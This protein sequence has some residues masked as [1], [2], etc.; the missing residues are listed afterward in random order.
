[1]TRTLSS[2]TIRF[3]CLLIC[4]GLFQQSATAQVTTYPYFE[5]FESGAG[6]WTAGKINPNSSPSSWVLTLPTNYSIDTAYSGVNAWVTGNSNNIA[7]FPQWSYFPGEFSAVTSPEFDFTNLQNPGI[8]VAIWW[9]SEFSQDGTCFQSSID[10]GMTWQTVGAYIDP[11]NWYN[12]SSVNGGML[13]GPGGQPLGWSGLDSVNT[14]PG[15]YVIAQ[16]G[17]DGLGGQPSVLL[18]FAFSSNSVSDSVSLSD[19]FAFDDVFIADRPIIDVGPDTLICFAERLILD[20]C[21]PGATT[22]QWNNNPIDTFCNIIAVTTGQ[23]FVNVTDTLGFI[24]SD[25]MNL[26]VSDTYA[27]L[28]SDIGLCPGDTFELDAENPWADHLW[29]P[30]SSTN[31]VIQ[32]FESGSFTVEISDSLGC[33]AVDSINVIVDF[34]PDTDL[35]A[36]TSICAGENI[37]LDASSGNPGTTY[38]WSPISASSQTVSIAA[39]GTYAVIVTS[40]FGCLTG[41]TVNI[42]VNP[43]PSVNLGVDRMVCPPFEINAGNT[44]ATYAWTTN[45]TTQTISVTQNGLYG[46]TVTTDSGCARYDEVNL[47]MGTYADANL[48]PDRKLCGPGESF[49]LSPAGTGASYLWSTGDVTSSITVTQAD[50]YILQLTSADGCVSIDTVNVTSSTLNVDLGPDLVICDGDV[51]TLDAGPLPDLYTWSTGES[52][53]RIQVSNSGMYSVLVEESGGC[54][55]RDS[56]FVTVEPAPQPTF[57][58][59]G[60]QAVFQSLQ[61]NDQSTG[62]PTNWSWDFGDGST[63]NLQNPTH[64]YQSLGDFEVCLTVDDGNCERTECQT[65]T[66]GLPSDLEAA[67]F[68][69][70]DVY[71]N[72]SQ[73]NLTLDLQLKDI[74]EVS[75]EVFDLRGKKVFGEV[76]G[77]GQQIIRNINL[78]AQDKGMYILQLNVGEFQVYRKLMIE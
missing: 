9:Q 47:T 20:V 73:G 32:L 58:V 12:D 21:T 61:F 33:V 53:R 29:L 75:L 48:G 42:G 46:V 76:L 43:L 66:I 7:G 63:S 25:T 10:G 28:G 8:Q 64:T 59:S 14:G 65:L 49:T 71:P 54:F 4:L 13:G 36:D 39:P 70:L 30:D 60:D 6:G 16:H 68:T 69:S 78:G 52:S 45:E 19:G 15:E 50:Q 56:V 41:D 1:M 11:V 44:N 3:F 40:P 55:R 31:Q 23:F 37:I 74:N 62:T 38:D 24:Q 67:L 27:N 51:I 72:P 77:K 35:G 57:S 17:L 34:V 22:Y 26:L 5:D 2:I 18:R